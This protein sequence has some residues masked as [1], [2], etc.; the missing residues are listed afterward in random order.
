MWTVWRKNIQSDFVDKNFYK[1]VCIL[2]CEI[3]LAVEI[4]M[5]L[6]FSCG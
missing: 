3:L 5:S 4:F 1:A 2:R 6:I